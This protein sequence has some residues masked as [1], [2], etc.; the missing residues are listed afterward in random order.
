MM[1]MMIPVQMQY[2][3]SL[4]VRNED[5]WS[6]QRTVMETIFKLIRKYW[7]FDTEELIE[8]VCIVL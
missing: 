1:K 5:N 7:A 4:I 6:V 2:C 8:Q 3:L